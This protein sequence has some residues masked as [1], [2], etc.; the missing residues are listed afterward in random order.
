MRDL[1]S[2]REQILKPVQLGLLP[3]SQRSQAAPSGTEVGSG[4]LDNTYY[5]RLPFL[6]LHHYRD[7]GETLGQPFNKEQAF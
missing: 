6:D 2:Q 7:K 3:S 1:W 5:S 4:Q